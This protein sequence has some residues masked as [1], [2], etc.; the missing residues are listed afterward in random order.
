MA[1][2]QHLPGRFP[3]P[4]SQEGNFTP[5]G[6]CVKAGDPLHDPVTD[7]GHAAGRPSGE[8][9]IRPIESE[10]PASARRRGGR[11]QQPGSRQLFGRIP[12]L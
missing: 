10:Q 7:F 2:A 5:F 11:P 4:D 9:S 3:G 8:S 12:R 6:R 1:K